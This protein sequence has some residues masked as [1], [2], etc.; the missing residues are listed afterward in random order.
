MVACPAGCPSRPVALSTEP[1]AALRFPPEVRQGLHYVPT[2]VLTA[3]V[4]PGGG[5][6]QHWALSLDNALLLAGV[7]CI[8]ISTLPRNLL[9]TI[10]GGLVVFFLL[11]WM[12]GQLPI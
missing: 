12:F 8:G 3:I 7:V 10:G 11:R 9:T 6:G 4:V 2:S 1:W 5:G